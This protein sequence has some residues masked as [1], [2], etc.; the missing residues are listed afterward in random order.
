MVDMVSIFVS[1][2]GYPESSAGTTNIDTFKPFPALCFLEI[3]GTGE[4]TLITQIKKKNR[5]VWLYW[6]THI[7]PSLSY[8]SL[9]REIWKKRRSTP[10]GGQF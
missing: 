2:A 10:L 3:S 9:W 6:F 1:H 8:Y 4:H 5:P 7:P